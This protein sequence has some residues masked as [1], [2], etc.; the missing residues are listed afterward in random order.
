MANPESLNDRAW[1]KCLI[2]PGRTLGQ[3]VQ[4]MTSLLKQLATNAIS[5]DTGRHSA[6]GT[7]EPQGQLPNLPSWWFNRTEAAR[8][9]QPLSHITIMGLEPRVQV[10]VTGRSKNFWVDTEATSSVLTSYSGAFSSQ[11]SIILSA[12][13]KTITKRFIWALL[14]CWGG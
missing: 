4:I 6:L 5:Q 8:S 12:M 3:T 13:G 1:N 11:T 10:D 7:Q 2:C 9:S 14:C